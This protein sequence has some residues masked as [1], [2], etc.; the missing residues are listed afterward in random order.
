[1]YPGKDASNRLKLGTTFLCS[2][3]SMHYLVMWVYR[4]TYFVQISML[5][6]PKMQVNKID[7]CNQSCRPVIKS[8][9]QPRHVF[10]QDSC[11]IN[12]PEED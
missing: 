12:H 1:M 4:K 8:I 3:A 6:M 7:V 9:N 2:A 5:F 10:L 11:N